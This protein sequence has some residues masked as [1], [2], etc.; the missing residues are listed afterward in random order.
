MVQ[1]TDTGILSACGGAV[2]VALPQVLDNITS[3]TFQPEVHF[4]TKTCDRR[5]SM[6][7]G[8]RAGGLTNAG[9]WFL[10]ENKYVT[11]HLHASVWHRRLPA[12]TAC[13]VKVTLSIYDP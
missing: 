6:N 2:N 7:D 10:H 9:A 8:C 11:G 13:H 4:G 5:R 1:A 12:Y 3:V